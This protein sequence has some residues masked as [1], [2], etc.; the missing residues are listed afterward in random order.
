MEIQTRILHKSCFSVAENKVLLAISEKSGT[1]K[2]LAARAGWGSQS[3]VAGTLGRLRQLGLV[4]KLDADKNWVLT[5][6]GAIV[7]LS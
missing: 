4:E 7:A 1:A 5:H 6:D 2:E 3:A